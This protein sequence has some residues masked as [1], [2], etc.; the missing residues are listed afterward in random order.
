MKGK[1]AKLSLNFKLKLKLLRFKFSVYGIGTYLN[2]IKKILDY[3]AFLIIVIT[4]SLLLIEGVTRL[5]AQPASYDFIERRIIEQDLPVK[6]AKDEYRIFLFGESTMHGHIYYPK[7]TIDKWLKMYL[8]NVLGPQDAKRVRVYNFGRL[9]ATSEFIKQA[10]DETLYY[11]PD[12]VVIYSAHNDFTILEERPSY[13]ERRPLIERLDVGFKLWIK[14][15]TFI[16]LFRKVSVAVKIKKKKKKEEAEAAAPDSWYIEEKLKKYDPKK[17]LF[18]Y[19]SQEAKRLEKRWQGNIERMIASAWKK[20]VPI[21]FLTALSKYKEFEPFES[22]HRPGLAGAQLQQW[23]MIRD[24]AEAEFK[25]KNY[26]SAAKLYESSLSLDPDYALVYFRLG[27]CLEKLQQYPK[28]KEYY[29]QANE[30]DRF[31]LRS[32][33]AVYAAYARLEERHLPGVYFIDTQKAFENFSPFQIVDSSLVIDTVH[34]SIKGQSL[35]ALEIAKLLYEE[36]LVASKDRW[37]WAKLERFEDL[38]KKLDLTDE[39]M[40]NVYL[41]GARYVGSYLDK[42]VEDL[43]RAVKIKP[44]SVLAR[45]QLAWVYWKKGEKEAALTIY[46]ELYKTHLD[47]AGA[48]QKKYPEIDAEIK[49]YIYNGPSGGATLPDGPS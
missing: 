25:N 17:D 35:M 30:K 7:S 14:K 31:P 9:G 3:L 36:N 41:E 27:E 11:K 47:L 20:K 1:T 13:L 49:K 44:D 6:K 18:Y 8:E 15:S 40:F 4:F 29:V 21:V 2:F 39:F 10:F 16:G 26:E 23:T 42:A 45:S 43:E 28:A 5:F 32:P 12:L 22:A 19:E 34:P 33:Q 46:Q 38:E 24:Q 48:F 37:Q